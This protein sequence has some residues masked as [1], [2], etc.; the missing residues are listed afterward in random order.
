MASLPKKGDNLEI[1]LQNNS[2]FRS[3]SNDIFSSLQNFDKAKEWADLINCIQKLQKVTS[4]KDKIIYQRFN[5]LI[6][7]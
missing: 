7:I 3:Y 2:K 1:E 5:R 6:L 4:I